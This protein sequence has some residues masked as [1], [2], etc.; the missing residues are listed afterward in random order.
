MNQI[1]IHISKLFHLCSGAYNFLWEK[2]SLKIGVN[3][4]SEFCSIL[5]KRKG[6]LAGRESLCRFQAENGLPKLPLG[7]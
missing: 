6:T 1:T 5:K 2:N 3:I 7:Y 4:S